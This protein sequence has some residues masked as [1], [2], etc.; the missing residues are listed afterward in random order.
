VKLPFTQAL[1]TGKKR[2]W[3]AGDGLGLTVSISSAAFRLE[4]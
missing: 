3:K 2:V 4:L 1:S